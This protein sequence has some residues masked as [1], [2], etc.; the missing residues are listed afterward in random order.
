[1]SLVCDK[2]IFISQGYLNGKSKF[3]CM[4]S[5]TKEVFFFFLISKNRYFIDEREVPKSTQG[6]DTKNHPI[7]KTRDKE[8]YLLPNQVKK[9]TTEFV[10]S[11]LNIL[12]QGHTKEVCI[13]QS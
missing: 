6:V 4:H 12:A 9:S 8:N 13:S 11:S 5:H 3:S 1:M 10:L 7:K 2:K